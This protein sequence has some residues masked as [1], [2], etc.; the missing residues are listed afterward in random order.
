[1]RG[2][3]WFALYPGDYLKDTMELT[4]AQHGAYFLL[5]MHYSTHGELPDDD[6]RLAAITRVDPEEWKAS[7]SKLMR[8]F[9]RPF[10]GKLRNQKMDAVLAQRARIV[11]RRSAAANARWNKVAVGQAADPPPAGAPAPQSP[12][13][14]AP[15][16]A[17]PNARE[18]LF[19]ETGPALCSLTGR[20]PSGA[21]KLLGLLLRLLSDDAHK[22]AQLVADAQAENP[23]DPSSWL[24][25]AARARGGQQ[26]QR[27]GKKHRNGF[28]GRIARRA[29]KA[30]AE[31][32]ALLTGGHHVAG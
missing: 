20:G 16:E 22:V 3:N 32:S 12:P 17:P 21:N 10:R 28:V 31:G 18:A 14:E 26:E 24:I 11:E 15:T 13:P 9:F 19:R 25:A 29:E 2:D 7:F 5:L 4:T 23:A 8:Q 1:M 27:N 6:G 30:R